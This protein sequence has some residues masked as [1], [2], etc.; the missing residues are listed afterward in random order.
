[1]A[2]NVW[3]WNSDWFG[4]YSDDPAIDPRG[5]IAGQFRVLRGGAYNYGP[6]VMRSSFRYGLEPGMRA[7]SL[8]VRCVRDKAP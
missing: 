8:G 2:G 4:A 1:M 5:G 7:V 6:W 3:E